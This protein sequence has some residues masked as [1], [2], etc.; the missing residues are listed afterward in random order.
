MSK[1]HKKFRKIENSKAKLPVS[2]IVVPTRSTTFNPDY[3]N[4]VKDL[5]RIGMLASLFF[6]V[7]IVLSFILK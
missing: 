5:K 4:V 6:I 3:S 2:S 1:K 7:L